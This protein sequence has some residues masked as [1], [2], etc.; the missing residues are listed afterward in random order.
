[1]PQPP[2]PGPQLLQEHIAQGKILKDNEPQTV[3]EMLSRMGNKGR[4]GA[5]PGDPAPLNKSGRPLSRTFSLAL[6]FI[7]FAAATVYYFRDTL[8]KTGKQAAGARNSS[9]VSQQSKAETTS[10]TSKV[11]TD[12]LPSSS[13]Q[14]LPPGGAKDTETPQPARST[15]GQPETAPH[16]VKQAA[17]PGAQP[18]GV[19]AMTATRAEGS[20]TVQI[21]SYA[22]AADANKLAERLKAAAV[23]A[24]VVRAALPNHRVVYRVLAGHFSDPD[25]AARFAAQL[26][27][28]GLAQDS[29]VKPGGWQQ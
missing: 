11:T 2:A 26:R 3:G 18:E 16:G 10:P 6:L 8:F 23:D 27:A 14:Q 17:L 19:P 9:S 4:A 7:V 20:L 1:M 5:R 12:P 15:E 24:Y 22:T 13:T 25:E 21:G 29:F 28:D